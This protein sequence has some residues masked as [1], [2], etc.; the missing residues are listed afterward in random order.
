MMPLIME[1]L[2]ATFTLH[3]L[4]AAQD[5]DAFM[6][7][8]GPRIRAVATGGHAKM[9]DAFMRRLPK[10]EIVAN[11]GVGYDSVDA[12]WAGPN[13]ILVTN[14]PDVLT[15]EVADTALG[16]LLMTVRELS[17]AERWLRAGQWVGKGP[18]PLT[19]HTLRGRSV[20]ILALG[21]IGKAI[22]KRCEAFG[23]TIAYHGRS[24]QKGVP[25]RYYANL[26]EMA[27]DVDILISVAPGGPDTFHIIDA[28]VLRALGPQGILINIGRG[29]VVD[30][31]ALIRALK[32]RTIASAGLDV[33]ENEPKVPEELLAMEHIVL[34]PHVGSGSQHTRRLMGQLVVDNIVSWFSGKGPITPV[35]E[36]PWPRPKG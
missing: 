12:A 15:E 36:T 20:G 34:L 21:R 14:T 8:V 32:D 7:A 10:L 31:P 18:F 4:P 6:A 25:Y 5:R 26:V 19:A 24:E 29:S 13:G 27:R 23:L 30:E 2:E 22:A 33:F 28:E 1:Q 17:A 16:L 11:F 3:R 9:D 35:A